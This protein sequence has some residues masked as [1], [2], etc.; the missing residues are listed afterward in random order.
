MTTFTREIAG[1]KHDVCEDS[2]Y[3]RE[4]NTREGVRGGVYVIGDGLSG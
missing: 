2:Y 3:F 1:H 4:F